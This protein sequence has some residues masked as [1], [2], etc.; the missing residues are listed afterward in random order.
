MVDHPQPAEVEVIP[1]PF[2]DLLRLEQVRTALRMVRGGESGERRLTAVDYVFLPLAAGSFTLAPFEARTPNG[3][4]LTREMSFLIP[5]PAPASRLRFRWIPPSPYLVIGETAEL[6]LVLETTSPPDDSLF[7]A[8]SPEPPRNA[9]IEVLPPR[10][11]DRQN[12]GVL[13]LRVIPL[14]GAE[15]AL[16]AFRFT[17][18]GT[19]PDLRSGEIPAY[20]IPLRPAPGKIAAGIHTPAA[21]IH[22][23]AAAVD[24]EPLLREAAAINAAPL[25]F[26]FPPIPAE[27]A[28]FPLFRG[29]YEGILTEVR[30]LWEEGRR[31]EAVA[32]IRLYERESIWALK[33][34]PLR[35]EMEKALGLAPGAD[36]I[37]RPQKV[38]LFFLPADLIL[39][40]L[41]VGGRILRVRFARRGKKSVTLFSSRC[42]NGITGFL[43]V[44]LIPAV[45]ILAAGAL[46]RGKDGEGPGVLREETVLHRIPDPQGVVES[47]FGEGQ[48]VIIR[49]VSGSWIYLEGPEGSGGWTLREKVIHY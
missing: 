32:E 15:L 10:E 30:H 24:P 20:K 33:L 26:P 48:R 34:R 7:Q 22:T 19:N 27:T 49:N 4:A 21:G 41:L 47:R 37:W 31:G 35:R 29:E 45:L 46:G 3:T 1:P 18:N 44:L 9:I 43:A 17:Y 28:S 11:E 39:I 25:I 6:R 2:P 16:P 40:C 38:F 36:E 23:T 13:R 12:G 42:F 5:G 14:E 8:Y